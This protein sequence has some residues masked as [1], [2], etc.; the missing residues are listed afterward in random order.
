MARSGRASRLDLLPVR[1]GLRDVAR[2]SGRRS[3]I[4]GCWHWLH[5]QRSFNTHDIVS[6]KLLNDSIE[7]LHS[8]L[9]A[10]LHRVDQRLSFRLTLL[11]VIARAHRG[12]QDLDRRNSSL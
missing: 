7:S 2:P 4:A 5:T 9:I 11:D 3:S 6:N 1:V 12:F 10:L 8:V